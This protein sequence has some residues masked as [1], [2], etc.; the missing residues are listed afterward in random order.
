MNILD[1]LCESPFHCGHD[2][3]TPDSPR[4]FNF[5]LP[6]FN[7][8]VLTGPYGW[9]VK[10][11]TIGERQNRLFLSR[12]TVLLIQQNLTPCAGQGINPLLT[13]GADTH[14]TP[15][16]LPRPLSVVGVVAAVAPVTP[17]ATHVRAVLV[18]VRLPRGL[19]PRPARD[20]SVHRLWWHEHDLFL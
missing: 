20:M 13:D 1:I 4:Y 2:G 5:K 16:L 15:A 14:T 18:E 7:C 19:R 12:G 9:A 17:E 6:L 11:Y 8:K 3:T 10:R